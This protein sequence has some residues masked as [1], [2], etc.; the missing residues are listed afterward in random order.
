MSIL[1]LLIE[2]SFVVQLVMLILLA[3][4]VMSWTMIFRRRKALS[5]AVVDAKK[6]EDR[7]WSGVDLAKLYNEVSARAAN[8]GLE[9]LFKAGFKEFARLHKTNSRQPAAVMEGTQRAMRV[10]LSREVERLEMHLPFLATV[11]SISPYIGLFGTVW[12]IMNSFIALGAVEQATL[13]M[14]AP[15]IAEALIATAIGLFAAIPA[16]IAYNKFSHQVEMLE[17]S[18]A[19]FVEEFANILHRQAVSNGGEA[20]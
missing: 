17:S 16:V 20:A 2:A 10:G 13:S 15:G 8:N 14:V 1:G 12:G 3:M 7:F 19:N 6:F 18:Y 5:E 11:G 4:S 9:A